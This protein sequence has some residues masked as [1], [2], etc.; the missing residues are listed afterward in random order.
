MGCDEP[1]PSWMD[2]ARERSDRRWARIRAM[3]EKLKTVSLSAFRA[4]HAIDICIVMEPSIVETTVRNEHKIDAAL[5]RLDAVFAAR[6][7]P[8]KPRRRPR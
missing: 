2:D 6:T 8:A 5:D 7:K 3:Q 1:R 4:D